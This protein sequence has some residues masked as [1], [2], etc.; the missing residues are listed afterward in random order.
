MSYT[1]SL[2]RV[3]SQNEN[4]KVLSVRERSENR[5]IRGRQSREVN[6]DRALGLTSEMRV[7]AGKSKKL[8]FWNV[9]ST[10][11]YTGEKR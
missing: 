3:I 4:G 6:F 2:I 9:N 1:S 11:T 10:F 5:F 8:F 7:L